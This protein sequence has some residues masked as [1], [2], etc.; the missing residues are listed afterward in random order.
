MTLNLSPPRKESHDLRVTDKPSDAEQHALSYDRMTKISRIT[1][2]RPLNG[3]R[4]RITKLYQLDKNQL[5]RD[6]IILYSQNEY[7]SKSI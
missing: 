6:L 4:E 2:D 5:I 3:K 7:N 1:S